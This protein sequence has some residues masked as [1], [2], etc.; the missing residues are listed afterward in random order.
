MAAHL[1]LL[2]LP[3][4]NV[5]CCP[6]FGCQDVSATELFLFLWGVS[7]AGRVALQTSAA[8]STGSVNPGL[9]S[10]VP[11]NMKDARTR[12]LDTLADKA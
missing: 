4:L 1:F 11:A 10:W 2:Y 12:E 3:G 6:E 7:A 8:L 5:F 9:P